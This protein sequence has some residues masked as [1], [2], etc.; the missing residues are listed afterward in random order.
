MKEYPSYLCKKLSIGS[1]QLLIRLFFFFFEHLFCIIQ[2]GMNHWGQHVELLKCPSPDRKD[3]HAPWKK[4]W[5]ETS[6]FFLFPVLKTLSRCVI[7]P[8]SY[9][10]LDSDCSGMTCSIWQINQDLYDLIHDGW[11]CIEET[12]LLNA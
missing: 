10:P 11:K 6:I 3:L 9:I 4:E 8:G 5:K 7:K 12:D 2:L 1:I